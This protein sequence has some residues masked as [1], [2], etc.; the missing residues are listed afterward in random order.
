MKAEIFNS[1]NNTVV[2]LMMAAIIILF[3]LLAGCEGGSDK[4]P[5]IEIEESIMSDPNP[6]GADVLDS[7]GVPMRYISAGDFITG[8]EQG[9][10]DE[11]TVH[12]VYLDAF[13]IDK[14]EVTNS[15]YNACLKAGV[16]RNLNIKISQ[17][18][19]NDLETPMDADK[20]VTFASW[21]DAKNFC[22]WREAQL[23]TEAQWEKAARGPGGRLYPSVIL[24]CL[25]ANYGYCEKGIVEVGSFPLGESPYGL[26]DMTGNV[27]E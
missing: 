24:S 8:N 10:E 3:V 2:K 25:Q 17:E 9:H 22:E 18:N 15:Q 13:Y 1:G 20:P 19:Q 26:F 4:T 7:F 21:Y 16:C 11:G 23:P 14:Y 12:V 27:S 5:V 6:D